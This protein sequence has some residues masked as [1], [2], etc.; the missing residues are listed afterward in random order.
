MFKNKKYSLILTSQK[1][2]ISKKENLLLIKPDK[3]LIKKNT[4]ELVDFSKI[5]RTKLINK[6]N[7]VENF[8]YLFSQKLGLE[9][10]KLLGVKYNN[11]AWEIIYGIWLRNFIILT[12]KYFSYLIHLIQKFNIK[13]VYLNDTE[14]FDF[15]INNTHSSTN[16]LRDRTWFYTY[17]SLIFSHLFKENQTITIVKKKLTMRSFREKKENK[18]NFKNYIFILLSYITR[19]FCRKNQPLITNTSLPFFFEKKLELSNFFAPQVYLEKKINYSNTNFNIRKNF[20]L[21]NINTT[22]NYQKFLQRNI[23]KFIP[24]CFLEDFHKINLIAKNYN[25]PKNPKCIFTSM[26]HVNDEVFKFYVANKVFKK[27]IPLYIGQHGN[28]IFT[29]IEQKNEPDKN[30]ST[31]YF[32][33]GFSN[34]KNIIPFFNFNAT[35]NKYVDRKKEK[36]IFVFDDVGIPSKEYLPEANMIKKLKQS[37]LFLKSLEKKIK[38]ETILRLKPSMFKSYFG[39]IYANK[40]TNL[41]LKFDNGDSRIEKLFKVSKLVVFNYDST[42]ILENYILGIPSLM[43]VQKNYLNYINKNFIKKYKLLEKNKLLFYDHLKL[44]KHVSD[45]WPNVDKWWSSKQTQSAIKYFNF[46]YNKK[47]K[48]KN[49]LKLKKIL[50]EN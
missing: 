27:K 37:E 33:W 22:S 7:E 3:L 43:L 15:S 6:L 20:F 1:L 31:R 49:L 40:F 38:K 36:L 21:N 4:S 18:K 29:R 11:K 50:Y 14:G 30:Y 44:S 12:E 2:N 16:A 9:L 24:K 48:Y 25:Y 23:V 45:I 13:K 32:S 46:N 34:K 8:Y 35:N 26:S 41:N 17:I 5:N 47:F 10:N 42:G 19:F 39:E 28:N